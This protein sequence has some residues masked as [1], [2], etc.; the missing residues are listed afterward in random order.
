[1]TWLLD[2]DHSLFHLI[3]GVWTHPALDSLM[4]IWTDL[5]KSPY[6]QFGFVPLVLIWIYLV[7]RIP[8]LIFFVL[9]GLCVALDDGFFGRIIKPLIDRPRP[10]LANLPFDV[11]L[12]A[13]Q[14]GGSSMPS[15]HACNMFAM[16]A[17]AGFYFPRL[18]GILLVFAAITAYSRVYCGV[19]FPSDVLAGALGGTLFGTGMAYAIRPSCARI[20]STWKKSGPKGI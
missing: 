4:P 18:R 19:H 14:F 7:A 5:H 2:L 17:F 8:G 10:P 9:T 3:N 16:A 1:M 6:F 11:I 12:R 20:Q 15:V 13:P